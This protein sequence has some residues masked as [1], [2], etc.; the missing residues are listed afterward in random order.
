MLFDKSSVFTITV[1]SF[2]HPCLHFH[3]KIFEKRAKGCGIRHSL[4]SSS[5]TSADS[6]R[7]IQ[8]RCV[9]GSTVRCRMLL[10]YTRIAVLMKLGPKN[11]API[12]LFFIACI[13]EPNEKIRNRYD[14]YCRAVIKKSAKSFAHPLCSY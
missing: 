10:L 8:L 14:Q 1:R 7:W 11:M 2:N 6:T 5:L 9:T 12:K 13:T 4:I 3:I